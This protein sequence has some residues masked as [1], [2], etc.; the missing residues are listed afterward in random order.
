MYRKG[1]NVYV[2]LTLSSHA[3]LQQLPDFLPRVLTSYLPSVFDTICLFGSSEYKFDKVCILQQKNNRTLLK[4]HEIE[5]K[6]MKFKIPHLLY[7][8]F[9]IKNQL[10][11]NKTLHLTLL[12][13]KNSNIS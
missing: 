7:I 4:L 8:E 6:E 5:Q 3:Y 12:N 13:C 9:H 2:K 1:K 11:L 10:V